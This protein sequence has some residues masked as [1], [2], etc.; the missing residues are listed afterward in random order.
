MKILH[1]STNDIA[2]GAAKASYQIHCALRDGGHS[3]RMIVRYKDSDD[4]DVQQVPIHVWRSRLRRVRRRIPLLRGPI[5]TYTFNFDIEPHADTRFFYARQRREIDII[6][7]HWITDFL[8]V[9]TI[10]EIYDYYQCPIIWVL[11]DQ[12]PVTGGCH[13][14][15]GCDGFTKQ[16]GNCPQLNT[17]CLED[18]SRVVWRRKHRYL[19]DLPIVFVAPTNWVAGRVKESSLFRD[20]KVEVIP[21]AIDTTTF[22]PCD[23]GVARDLLHVPQDKR[24]IFFGAISLEDPRKGMTYLMKALQQLSSMVDDKNSVL[25]RE[26]VFLLA[27]GRKVNSLLKSMPFPSRHLGYLKDDV[28]LA[29]A[30]QAADVFVSSSVE[31]AGPM[32]IPEA[33]L[34]GSP[35]VAFNTG[36]AP[37]LIETMKTGYLATYKDSADLAKGIYSLLARNDLSAIRAAARE[38]AARKHAP[39]VVAA[40]HLELHS[41]LLKSRQALRDSAG[42][43]F[44]G[45]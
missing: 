28:T 21:L 14:S 24:V 10:R 33:M 19:H 23:Q 32:M 31:D 40:R 27:A 3:S 8:T 9:R 13:Y 6:L 30:Y 26:D 16:C 4:K 35:V 17:N 39:S 29:L 11:M 15:F 18:R 12:E 1:F 22:C 37:D 43:S 41:S 7:L 38:V 36:G 2:G 45:H 25:S 5:A 44:G 34:C 20:H 42:Y